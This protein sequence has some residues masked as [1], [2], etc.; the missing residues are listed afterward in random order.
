M[1][2]DKK[3]AGRMTGQGRECS[4]ENRLQT[5]GKKITQGGRP[6]CVCR[7]GQKHRQICVC[8]SIS[9]LL[10]VWFVG[11]VGPINTLIVKK[12]KKVL[13]TFIKSKMQ[14]LYCCC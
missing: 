14:S 13:F 12:N 3:A 10:S 7:G 4:S 5:L 9:V 11:R 1:C 6:V 2:V 8:G